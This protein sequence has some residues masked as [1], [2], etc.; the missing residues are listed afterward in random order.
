MRYIIVSNGS[1]NDYS[2]YSNIISSDDFVICADGGAKHL[3]KMDIV[4]N[5]IIGDLDSID[6]DHKKKFLEKKVEFQKFPTNK[7]ATD[8]ELALDFALSHN[9]SE[10]IFI[11]TLG[12][13]MDHSIANVTLLKKVLDKKIKGKMINENNEIYI[14]DEKNNK[15]L[16]SGE[17][18]EYLSLIP[19]CNKV[20]GV[21]LEGFKYPL[22]DAEISFGS[23]I[24]V[25]NEFAKK[26]ASVRITEGLLLVIKAKD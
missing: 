12:S 2:F 7:D 8:T 16:L 9:P 17:N 18:Y 14:I 13:R 3:I 4:P 5:V 10:I 6:E 19:L 1:I 20:I 23:S 15:L 26:Q 21:T 24:G 22:V 25:S 11:G